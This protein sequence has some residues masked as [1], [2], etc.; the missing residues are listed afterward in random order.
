M[1]R[2]GWLIVAAV[3]PA[4][5]CVT[6]RTPDLRQELDALKSQVAQLQQSTAELQSEV[7]SLKTARGAS[8]LPATD[9]AG[10]DARIGS[11]DGQLAALRQRLDDTLDRVN[12]L[13]AESATTR[14]L[15]MR[16]QPPRMAPSRPPEGDGEAPP[17][18][19]G[20]T[21]GLEDTHRVPAVLEDTYNAAYADFAKGD[22]ALAISGFQDFLKK[23]PQSELADNAQH[24]IGEAYFAQGEFESALA[25]YD[26]VIRRYPKGDR[27]P[28][29]LL[30]KGLCLIEASRT[31]EGVVQL[32]HLIQTHPASEEA[33]LARDRLEEMG[34]KP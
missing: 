34:I 10:L 27:V 33:A 8:S 24:W 6:T 12:T 22:Y 19:E 14:E 23:Y 7:S 11:L 25:Q 9:L 2:W 28:A 30:K 16:V 4:A 32:Q 3:L 1:R 17:A 18:P 29:A 13:A 15:A 20:S 5:G 26:Q 31:A 21:T